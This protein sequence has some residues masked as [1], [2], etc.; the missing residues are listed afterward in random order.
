MSPI[1]RALNSY[2]FPSIMNRRYFLDDLKIMHQIL[3]NYSSE[4]KPVNAN[5]IICIK[6]V[7]CC[8]PHS[9]PDHV[10]HILNSFHFEGLL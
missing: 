9:R 5:M 10:L 7:Y 2:S 3:I 6:E 8:S 4:T 1:G